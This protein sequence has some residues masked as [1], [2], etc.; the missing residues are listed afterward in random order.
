MSGSIDRFL[1]ARYRYGKYEC[2]DFARDVWLWAT[3]EDLSDRLGELISAGSGRRIARSRNEVRAFCKLSAPVDP[4]LV[5]MRRPRSQP[6]AGVYLRG[7]VLHLTER[8]AEF[9]APA[10]ASRGF[11][12]VSYYR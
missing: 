10:L 1:A 4:C 12:E 3:G 9:H 7:R 2:L 6:H 8:G 11:T 5:L